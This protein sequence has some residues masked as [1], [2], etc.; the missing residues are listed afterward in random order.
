M[1]ETKNSGNEIFLDIETLRLSHEVPGGWSNIRQ[2]GL[3]VAVTWDQGHGFRR[4]F[5]EDAAHLVAELDQF[6]RVITFN[7]E[8]FDL[9]VLRG[10]SP[11]HKLAAKSLDLLVHLKN[12]LGF[13]VK[14]DSLAEATLG[15]RKTGAG[16]E[17]VTWW[18]AGDKERV[19]K[20]CENDV[21]LLVDLVGF[22]REKGYVIVDRKRVSVNW[23]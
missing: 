23:R 8:R 18:R 17:V 7:G 12:A 15:R 21:Q 6:S 4:W 5:E 13:R 16:E 1:E 14:L 20:Y 2:F 9:E 19:C 3:A 11:T 10:Y 22:A